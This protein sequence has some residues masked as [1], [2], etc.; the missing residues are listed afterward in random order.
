MIFKESILAYRSTNSSRNLVG[1]TTLQ[2]VELHLPSGDA[3][4]N[5]ALRLAAE[6]RDVHGAVTSI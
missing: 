1:F 5:Y 6:I 3:S 2:S 4:N